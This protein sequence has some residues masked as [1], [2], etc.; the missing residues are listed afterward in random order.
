MKD[1]DYEVLQRAYADLQGGASRAAISRCE[2]TLR[3]LETEVKKKN[4]VVE[5][6][7]AQREDA[8]RAA[9]LVGKKNAALALAFRQRADILLD[10]IER[11]KPHGLVKKLDLTRTQHLN[12][13]LIAETL[14]HMD[15]ETLR[16]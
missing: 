14:D 9:D 4:A 10:D 8:L 5:S 3:D 1:L 12:L 2:Q 13:Q 15:V 7:V 11:Q 6:L 16:G